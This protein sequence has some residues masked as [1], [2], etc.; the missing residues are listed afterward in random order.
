MRFPSPESDVFLAPMEGVNDLAFRL[1]CRRKGAGIAFT[2][3][4]SVNALARRNKAS[5]RRVDT[6]DEERPFRAVQLFGQLPRLF[7]NAAQFCED[8]ADIIDLNFGCPYP[9]IMQ[10]GAGSALLARPKRIGEIVRA[11][12]SAVDL[13]VTCKLRIGLTKNKINI[14]DT[15]G[16]ANFIADGK[17]CLRAV[18][19]SILVAD[20][21]DGVRVQGE[22]IARLSKELGLTV[23][24][25]VNKMDRER[26]NFEKALQDISIAVG[27]PTAPIYIPIGQESSFK[28]L[29]DL[30]RKKALFFEDDL[31]GKFKEGEV[32]DELSKDVEKFREKLIEAQMKY[33][34]AVEKKNKML[35]Q[36]KALHGDEVIAEEASLG[37]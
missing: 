2:Q 8:K 16:D 12:C 13:P 4:V 30:L 1:L 31:S 26:A 14:L 5:I 28:G 32:P 35:Q 34:A 20:S 23:V 25:F 27:I 6:C 33:N 10:Q 22:K 19:S 37:K 29:I 7:A 21:A 11:V 15:P 17:N 9:N 18:E 3:M 24:G 36:F